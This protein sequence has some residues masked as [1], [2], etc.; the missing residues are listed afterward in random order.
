MPRKKINFRYDDYERVTSPN[1]QQIA[2]LLKRAKGEKNLKQYAALCNVSPPMMSMIASAKTRSPLSDQ[3]IKAIA[4]NADPNSG[5][6]EE[7]LLEANGMSRKDVGDSFSVGIASQKIEESTPV[8]FGMHFEE[9]AREL[10]SAR[11]LSKGYTLTQNTKPTKLDGGF[12]ML[13]P[14]FE[15]EIKVPDSGEVRRW[16]FDTILTNGII[17]PEKL[18][19]R[20][21]TIFSAAYLSRFRENGI[22]F[23]FVID[24]KDILEKLK[25]RFESM[26]IDDIISIILVDTVSRRIVEEYTL[27][28]TFEESFRI[29]IV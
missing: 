26:K 22:I 9:L 3:L 16:C 5:V 19:Q 23:S 21:S 10:I 20:F 27:P 28:T 6:T 25:S 11:L 13:C 29:N 1:F 24:S 14:D 18:F 7:L 8:K 2:E 17:S 15:Y 4:D 12:S